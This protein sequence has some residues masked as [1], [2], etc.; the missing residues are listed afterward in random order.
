MWWRKELGLHPQ[1]V[2]DR[3]YFG[4][5]ECAQLHDVLLFLL[6]QQGLVAVK[7]ADKGGEGCVRGGDPG[8]FCGE[9]HEGSVA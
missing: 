8:V 9:G 6:R 7:V 3:P 4:I 1:V 2:H 5:E